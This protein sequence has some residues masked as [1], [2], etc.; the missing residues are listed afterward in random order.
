MEKRDRGD[1]IMWI[2]QMRMCLKAIV[3]VLEAATHAAC[4]HPFYPTVVSTGYNSKH[5]SKICPLMQ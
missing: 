4:S 3:R 2:H 5:P 1:G